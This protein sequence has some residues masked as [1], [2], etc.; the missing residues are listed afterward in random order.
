MGNQ[1]S[2]QDG[3]S[4]ACNLAN[5]A[6][7]NLQIFKKVWSQYKPSDGDSWPQNGSINNRI[8]QLNIFF[9]WQGKWSEIVYVQTLFLLWEWE[10]LL[11]KCKLTTLTVIQPKTLSHNPTLMTHNIPSAVPLFHYRNLLSGSASISRKKQQLSHLN[12]KG[13]NN[14]YLSLPG[15]DLGWRCQ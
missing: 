9:K 15:S 5:W 14:P 8:L 10:D 1:P 11:Q 3:G 6:Q 13:Q 12:Q 2:L 4:L 7:F